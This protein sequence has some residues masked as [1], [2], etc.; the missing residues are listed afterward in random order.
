MIPAAIVYVDAPLPVRPDLAAEHARVWRNLAMPG[1]WLDASQRVA[2]AR[3]T[4]EAPA[5][6]TCQAA[7]SALSPLPPG[8]K[9]ALSEPTL[10]AVW[11]EV[12]HRVRND[13]SRLTDSWYDTL[14]DR[15]LSAGEYIEIVSVLAHVVAI[16][17]FT[18]ALGWPRHA[19]PEPMAGEPSRALPP[20]ARAG[21]GRVPTVAPE[22]VSQAEADLYQNLS[23][24]NIHRALSLVPAEVWS[25]FALD[26]VMYLP[27]R[28]LRDFD[29]E[30]R[31]IDH[32]QIELVAARV[33]ALNECYY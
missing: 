20:G 27:D 4:R 25:F 15:G 21:L 32:A 29:H 9:H 23:G 22:D 19:L 31:A 26:A 18:D 11:N 6:P 14:I 28:Q 1:T 24:A 7:A 17:T 3:A 5:C 8:A 33:S 10:P 2:V 16:D 13:A 30:F 12:V